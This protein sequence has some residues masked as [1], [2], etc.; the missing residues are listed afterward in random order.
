M[1]CWPANIVG[2]F[3]IAILIIDCILGTY[4]NLLTHSIVGIIVTIVFSMICTFIGEDLSAALLVVPSILAL[5]FVLSLWFIGQS[6]KNRGY[7]M[8]QGSSDE[9]ASTPSPSQIRYRNPVDSDITES[10]Y[11]RSNKNEYYISDETYYFFFPWLKPPT[12]ED[13]CI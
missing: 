12:E 4:G 7:C 13:K 9:S 1:A 10:D 6:L 2:A 5:A 11:K 8:K 3:F